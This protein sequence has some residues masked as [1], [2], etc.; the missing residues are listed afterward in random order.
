MSP[1]EHAVILFD[2]GDVLWDIAGPEPLG[3]VDIS[4]VQQAL[5]K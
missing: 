1:P 2:L 4:R 3:Q 5:K